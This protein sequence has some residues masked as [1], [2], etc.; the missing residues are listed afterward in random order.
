MIA[1]VMPQGCLQLS[2]RDC[3]SWSTSKTAF[4]MVSRMQDLTWRKVIEKG[5]MRMPVCR[6]CKLDET[7]ICGRH[8]VNAGQEP[9]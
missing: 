2:I 6:S 8:S 5:L 7:T 9:I 1:V 4:P 3:R